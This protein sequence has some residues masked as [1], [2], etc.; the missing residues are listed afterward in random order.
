MKKKLREQ[1]IGAWELVS[2]VEKPVDGS[3]TIYPF[4]ETPQGIIM[5]TPDGF[6]SAQICRPNRT[7]F[8]SGDWF[9]GTVQEYENEASSYLAYTGPFEVDEEKQTLT[10][11][12]YISL[13][14][15][16]TGQTQPRVVKFED[17]L[18]NL[19]AGPMQSGGKTVM[20]YLQWKRANKRLTNI[21]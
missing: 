11:S 8:S 6:M 1:L 13:F 18:L 16:W 10:H 20:A 21:S 17:D 19:S 7:P 14:P 9:K 4:S 12:M 5:Y 3:A 15:N 2:Y